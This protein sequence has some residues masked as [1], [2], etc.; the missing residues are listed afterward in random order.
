M[1]YYS[2]SLSVTTSNHRGGDEQRA[3]SQG[4]G[5]SASHRIVRSSSFRPRRW[6]HLIPGY[7][8]GIKTAPSGAVSFLKRSSHC[9]RYRSC[10]KPGWNTPLW[11]NLK[12]GRTTRCVKTKCPNARAGQLVVRVLGRPQK[13]GVLPRGRKTNC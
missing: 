4:G 5:R 10:W 3:Q 13:I 7:K 2:I 9:W 11:G 12:T 6:T 8:P 1:Y